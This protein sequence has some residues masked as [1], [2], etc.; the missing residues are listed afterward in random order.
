MTWG[1]LFF[2]G[3]MARKRKTVIFDDVIK[4]TRRIILQKTA[5]KKNN[6]KKN[7]CPSKRYINLFNAETFFVHELPPI[8]F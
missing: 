8:V 5:T 6:N 1:S 3:R 4:D 2:K 7:S